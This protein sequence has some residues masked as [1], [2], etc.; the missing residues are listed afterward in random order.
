MSHAAPPHAS[1]HPLEH[2]APG[3][4]PA[5]LQ[6]HFHDAAQQASAAKF[7]MWLFLA[8]EVL[9]FGGL[10]MGYIALRWFYPGSFLMAHEELSVPMGAINTVVLIT[11]SL[12]MA[13]AVRCAQLGDRV[14]L[15][16]HLGLTILFACAFLVVKYFEYSS[17]VHHGFLP[18]KHY[19]GQGL[20]G[21]PELF[22]SCYFMMTGLHGIHVVGGIVVLTWILVKASRGGFSPQWYTPV[23]NVGLYWHLVDLIWIFLFPLLYLMR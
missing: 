6:H 12:T 19:T 15:V 9:F 5:F 20:E 23:E 13:L 16:R 7:G 18:G 14:W 8:T 1:Q 4:H 17:K 21:M 3:A 2:G 11:S 10:F 22:F